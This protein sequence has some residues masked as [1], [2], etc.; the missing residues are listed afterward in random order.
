MVRLL[1]LFSRLMETRLSTGE[2]SKR[3]NWDIFYNEVKGGAEFRVLAPKVSGKP[4]EFTGETVKID[5]REDVL[6]AISNQDL[7][8]F[9]KDKSIILPIAGAGDKGIRLTNLYKDARFGGKEGSKQT[10]ER[11]ESGLITAINDAVQASGGKV[12]M[13]TKKDNLKGV[14]G[15]TKAA[16]KHY[17]GKEPYADIII[18]VGGKPLAISAKGPRAPSI[19]GGGLAGIL[20]VPGMGTVVK[21]ATETAL[22]FYKENYSHLVGQ[23]IKAK[24]MPEIYVRI[25]REYKLKLLQGT[26]EM[27]GPIDYMYI[28]SMNV[29][30]EYIDGNLTVNGSLISIDDYDDMTEDLYLRIRRRTSNQVLDLERKDKSGTPSLFVGKGEPNRRYVIYTRAMIPNNATAISDDVYVANEK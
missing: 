27:G 2:L 16:P 17:S 4:D 10:A 11:Q 12:D 1:E 5:P 7:S 29:V 21:D 23:P 6:Q 24:M 20:T 8:G 15:A 3:S 25:P 19:A 13:F 9:I 18:N 14:T 22:K 30:S 26:P 28:G